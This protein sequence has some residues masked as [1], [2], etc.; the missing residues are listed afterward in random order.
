MN[1]KRNS[2]NKNNSNNTKSADVRVDYREDDKI[3][4]IQKTFQRKA[5]LQAAWGRRRQTLDRWNEHGPRVPQITE[6]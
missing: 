4:E 5:C 1:S 2:N 6:V 3:K